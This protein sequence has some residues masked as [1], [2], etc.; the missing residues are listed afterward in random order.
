M[1]YYMFYE[2]GAVVFEA[3]ANTIMEAEEKGLGEHMLF[4]GRLYDVEKY[5]LILDDY[6][7][8]DTKLGVY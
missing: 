3:K 1:K 2:D 6:F 7:Q 8:H 4:E 5:D